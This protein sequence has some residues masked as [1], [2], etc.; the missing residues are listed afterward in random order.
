[1]NS[2][3]W[4]NRRLLVPRWRSFVTTVAARELNSR[5]PKKAKPDNSGTETELRIAR[6]KT[7][8]NL[9]TA[10]QVVE[11]ALGEARYPEAVDAA[12][13]ILDKYPTAM[14]MVQR[15]AAALLKH[16]G[17]PDSRHADRGDVRED[18]KSW[19]ASLKLYP[20]DAIGWTELALH[21]VV[22]G[23]SDAAAKSVSIALAIAPHNRHI[24]RSAARLYLHREEHDR[25]HDLIARNPASR[26]DPWLLS[27][28]IALARAADRSPR[29]MKFG[30]TLLKAGDFSALDLSEL[31]GAIGTEYL[32]EGRR[33][34][35]KL[36]ATSLEDPTASSLAQGEWASREIGAELVPDESI[37][38][39]PEAFEAM[40]FHRYREFRFREVP[41][42]CN[43]WAKTDS[44]SV[45]PYEFG[46]IAAAH[47]QDFDRSIAMAYSGLK[48]RPDGTR[49]LHS[50]AFALASTDR[51]DEA[52]DAIMRLSPDKL[53]ARGRCI[54]LA[55]IGLCAFRLGRFDDG[56]ATYRK[57][58][59]RLASLGAQS[60][61]ASARAYLA[62]EATYAGLEDAPKFLQEAEDH[63][64]QFKY[65]ET[66]LVLKRLRGEE[67]DAM[68]EDKI[69][70]AEEATKLATLRSVRWTTPGFP[71]QEDII[72]R[73]LI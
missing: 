69:K 58:I 18:A 32:L 53:D 12:R 68:L 44:F 13:Q 1:M 19:R 28:E 6:W 43:D 2:S 73:L 17:V 51:V 15:Q 71:G 27:A 67:V 36:F 49:L 48:L 25:A 72:H 11:A 37:Q 14:P 60:E 42:I 55:N 20:N 61:S 39:V 47:A 63:L 21:Q 33:G 65:A 34:L 7:S 64:R 26:S 38:R 30:E 66:H 3:A 54:R 24:L 29:F 8:P 62:R 59:E 57:A 22:N 70:K 31:A 46:S 23:H 10:M 4:M 50:L 9:L 40:A 52:L 41:D 56:I 35:R 45:R 5:Q 16:A